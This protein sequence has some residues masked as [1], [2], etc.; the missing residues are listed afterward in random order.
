MTG[1]SGFFRQKV[2]AIGLSLERNTPEVPID[3][4]YYVVL[5]CQIQGRYRQKGQ[6]QKVY[7]RLLEESGYKPEVAKTEEKNE[8]VERYLDDLEAYWL[9]SHKHS[10]R[11]GKGR[12]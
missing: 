9:D 11:G 4:W 2:P 5:R 3:G 7:S 8:T 6:A 12:F 10:K 1:T